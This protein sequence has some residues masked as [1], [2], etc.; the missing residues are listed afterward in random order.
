MDGWGT[1]ILNYPG[2]SS[3]K[4]SKPVSN[5]REYVFQLPPLRGPH[6]TFKPLHCAKCEYYQCYQYNTSIWDKETI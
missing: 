4:Y 5:R 2:P 3:Q 6:L 1:K